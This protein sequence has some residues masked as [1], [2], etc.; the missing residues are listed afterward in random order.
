VQVKRFNVGKMIRKLSLDEWNTADAS[1]RL[2]WLEFGL[3]Q[4]VESFS[5][6]TLE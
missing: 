5:S 1:E 6:K 2:H 4:D 3:E